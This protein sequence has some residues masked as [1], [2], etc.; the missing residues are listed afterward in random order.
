MPHNTR[1]IDQQVTD[2]ITIINSRQKRGQAIQRG[3]HTYRY[4]VY[5]CKRRREIKH[6]VIEVRKDKTRAKLNNEPR[7]VSQT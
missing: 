7:S 4:K 6:T 2:D 1:N 5:L 3:N